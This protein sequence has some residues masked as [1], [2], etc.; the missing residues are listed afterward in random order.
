MQKVVRLMRAV[1]KASKGYMR[2]G[3]D[4]HPMFMH[5]ARADWPSARRACDA[6]KDTFVLGHA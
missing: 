3:A 4:A 6:R 1:T 2:T 5:R